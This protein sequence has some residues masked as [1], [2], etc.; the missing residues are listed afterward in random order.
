MVLSLSS[1][2]KLSIYVSKWKWVLSST[3]WNMHVYL[4]SLGSFK[5]S[6]L[7]TSSYYHRNQQGYI[8]L[9]Y[10]TI[11]YP[12]ITHTENI[13][14]FQLWYCIRASFFPSTAKDNSGH[15][16]S[17]FQISRQI[18]LFGYII[19]I[20]NETIRHCTFSVFGTISNP[21]H[22][23]AQLKHMT[24]PK[25]HD[26]VVQHWNSFTTPILQCITQP[27]AV[28]FAQFTYAIRTTIIISFAMKT[29]TKN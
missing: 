9:Q 3:N 10:P 18:P 11:S 25:S 6:L 20:I 23:P 12:S 1:K 29:D 13:Y 14:C 19:T 28:H 5:T 16:R 17:N 26:V 27:Q 2:T 15:H 8:S 24:T 22:R 21:M 4:I 7:L